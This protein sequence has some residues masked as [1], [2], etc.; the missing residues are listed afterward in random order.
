M[1]TQ[2]RRDPLGLMKPSEVAENLSCSEQRVLKMIHAGVFGP[3][4]R[5]GRSYRI[6][7]RAYEDYV[8]SLMTGGE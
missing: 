2:Q 5:L 7:R 6:P 3:K 1:T 8:T 4:V